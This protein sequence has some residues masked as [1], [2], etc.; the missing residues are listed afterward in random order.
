[1]RHEASCEAVAGPQQPAF[2]AAT[3]PYQ[4]R[5]SSLTLVVFMIAPHHFD[6]S[7]NMLDT[8][9][10]VNVYLMIVETCNFC[11]KRWIK[12]VR[13]RRSAPS[14]RKPASNCSDCW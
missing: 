9:S 13:S 3:P 12:N 6:I 8:V 5:T 4:L 14:P 7:R 2:S 10:S 1:M 11:D